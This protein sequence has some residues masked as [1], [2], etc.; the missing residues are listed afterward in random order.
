MTIKERMNVFCCVEM[1]RL[2]GMLS[3]V[4]REAEK[5]GIKMQLSLEKNPGWYPMF[6]LVNYIPNR[7]CGGI[8]FKLKT[9]PFCGKEHED[10][11]GDGK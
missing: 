3:S 7:D 11:T 1:I 2:S 5:E 9:C 8:A 6:S 4:T 10:E